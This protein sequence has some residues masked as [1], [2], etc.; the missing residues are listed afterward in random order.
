MKKKVLLLVLAFVLVGG[1]AVSSVNVENAPKEEKTV[2]ETKVKVP[3]EHIAALEKAK[4]YANELYLSKSR[5]YDQ[6]T[7]EYGE[8]F[9]NESAQ[10]AIDHLDVD[11][12]KNALIKAKEYRNSM[13][14]SNESIREQL[15]SSYGERFTQ[16]EA[17][18]AIENLDK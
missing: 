1:C 11:Y 13:S 14:M 7:S 15:T 6:L 3:E 12:K 2:Q 10:Y 16:E 8:K 4:M 9:S 18:F 17:D 5:I